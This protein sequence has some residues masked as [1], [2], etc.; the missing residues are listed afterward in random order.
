MRA[1]SVAPRAGA[2]IET[3]VNASTAHGDQ[4]APRAGAWIETEMQASGHHG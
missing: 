2:W 3:S 4:V 1:Y